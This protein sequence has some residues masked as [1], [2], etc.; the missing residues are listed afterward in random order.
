M[1][2]F[3][4]RAQW[5]KTTGALRR[6]AETFAAVPDGRYTADKSGC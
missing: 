3:R 5:S 6:V 4:F 1:T 2:S